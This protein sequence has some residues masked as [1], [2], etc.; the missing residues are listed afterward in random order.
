MTN[1]TMNSG[2]LFNKCVFH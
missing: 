1:A 2:K